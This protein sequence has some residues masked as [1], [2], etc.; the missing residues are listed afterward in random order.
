MLS[1]AESPTDADQQLEPA[2]I[3]QAAVD[4]LTAG[5]PARAAELTGLLMAR[6]SSDPQLLYARAA[7]LLACGEEAGGKAAMAIT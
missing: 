4:A 2:L 5:Q 7:A 1:L 6:F 3:L